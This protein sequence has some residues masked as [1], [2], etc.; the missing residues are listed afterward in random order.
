MMSAGK[1]H[2]LGGWPDDAAFDALIAKAAAD[3]GLTTVA[4]PD[5][6][7]IR[8]TGHAPVCVQLCAGAVGI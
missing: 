5:G 6:L 4:L 1:V 7:R 8:D 2:Y 3:E